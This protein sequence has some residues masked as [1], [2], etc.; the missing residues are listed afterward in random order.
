MRLAVWRFVIR[1]RFLPMAM[2]VWLADRIA[3]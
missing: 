3:E 2:R 1:L